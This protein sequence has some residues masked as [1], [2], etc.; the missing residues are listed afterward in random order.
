MAFIPQSRIPYTNLNPYRT[1]RPAT[2]K[3]IFLSCE[4]SVTE[5][6]Y[7]QYISEMFDE[8]KSKIQFVSVVEDE[9]HTIPKYRTQEQNT[10]LSKSKPKQLLE[11]IEQFKIEKDSIYQFA[12]HEEDEFWI[13]MDIDQNLADDIKDSNDKSFKDYFIETLDKCDVRG[14]KYA[15]SNPFF[16]IWLLLHHDNPIEEDKKYA[17]T[18]EHS[19]E[20]TGHYRQRMRELGVP[21]HGNANKDIKKEDYTKEKVIEAVKR[22]E[23]LHIDKTCRYPEYFAT[24]VYQLLN[25]L[26]SLLPKSEEI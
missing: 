4:G 18:S 23:S 13:I 9:I 24:T 7:F 8:L 5:E 2:D 1:R 12:V 17:V 25:K 15:I 19:Y 6:E 22:A 16:E 20:K 26:T 11:K 10:K 21:M 14:Y 3:I